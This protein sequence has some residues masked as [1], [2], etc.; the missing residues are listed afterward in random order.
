MSPSR[1]IRAEPPGR[2]RAAALL[3][4]LLIGLVACPVGGGPIGP[5]DPGD[6][7][8]SNYPAASV[9]ELD[10]EFAG[11]WAGDVGGSPGTLTIGEL[12]ERSY[13]GSFVTD[14]GATEYTLLLQHSYVTTSEGGEVASNR[15]TFTWQ[16]GLG[17]RG[18]GWLLINREDTAVTG[19]FGYGQAT[20]GLGDWSFI[21]FDL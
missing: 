17:S 6:D 18:K 15:A 12:D 11:E 21:R 7:A 10:P 8:M 14:D 16:D 19:S 9:Y 3:G 5:N 20:S 1:S 13:Y 2:A 4:A